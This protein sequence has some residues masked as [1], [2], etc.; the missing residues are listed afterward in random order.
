MAGPVARTGP[1]APEQFTTARLLLRRPLPTDAEAIFSRYASDIE[2]TRYLSWP[3]HTALDETDA[4]VAYSDTEWRT[5]GAGPY[6]LFAGGLLVGSTG[7][8]FE[9]ASEAST[10]YLITRDAWGRGYATE[11][12]GAMCDLARW[13]DLSRLYA[14]CHTEHAASRRVMEK[15]GF[16]S[17]GILQRHTVFPNIGPDRTDVYCYAVDPRQSPHRL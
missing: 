4:F 15:C 11:A 10:G 8:A 13:L 16:S 1:P 7:L 5:W 3:R 6:V 9:N 17:E 2:V 12:L 14:V